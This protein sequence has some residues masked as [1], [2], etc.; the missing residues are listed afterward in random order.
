MLCRDSTPG[1]PVSCSNSTAQLNASAAPATA[2]GLAR[3]AISTTSV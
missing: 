1:T 2:G 3:G